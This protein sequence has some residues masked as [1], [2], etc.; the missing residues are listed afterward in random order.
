MPSSILRVHFLNVGLC[1]CC[2]I[3]ILL[4][5][6]L[7]VIA[8]HSK[9][10]L[11]PKTNFSLWDNKVDFILSPGSP[12]LSERPASLDCQSPDQRPGQCPGQHHDHSNNHCYLTNGCYSDIE[13]NHDNSPIATIFSMSISNAVRN[14]GELLHYVYKQQAERIN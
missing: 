12:T 11:Q 6:C 3:C 7:Y 13:A 10:T 4:L 2:P 9:C 14:L 8:V 5:S 1:D